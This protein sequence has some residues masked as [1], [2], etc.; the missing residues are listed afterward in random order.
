MRKDFLAALAAG[1]LASHMALAA[2]FRI[3]VQEDPDV[4]DPHRA[5]TT[6]GRMVF[7]S[8]CDKLVD[9]TDKLEIAPQLASSWS[10]STDNKTLTFKL[11]DDV[12]FHDG[13]TFDASAVKANLDRAMTLPDSMRKGELGSV[14]RVEVVDPTTVVLQLKQADA[15]LLSQLTDRAGMMLSPASF[16]GGDVGRKPICSGPYRFVERVQNDR[17]VLE[18]FP[19]YRDAKDYHFDRVI[20]LPIPDTTV[21][22]ANLQAGDLELVERLNPSDAEAVKAD[23]NLAFIVLPGL[24]FQNL[25][26]N[27]GPS[28]QADTPLGRDKLVRQALQAAI[29]RD[30]VNE[31]IGHGLFDPAQHPFPP[32]S[33]YF[34]KRYPVTTRDVAK[35]KALLA[36]ARQPEVAL[37]L[38]FGNTTITASLAEM[39]Q[40]MAGEAG[41]K[42]SLRPMEFAAMLSEMQK[43]NFQASLNGWSGRIDPDGNIHQ[44]VTC[45]G[46]QND[47]KYCNPEID[48]LLNEARLTPD[49][50]TR[51]GLYGQALAILQSD[52]PIIYTYYQPLL[53]A[54]SK[55][56]ADFKPYPDGM[57][58]LRGV[59]PAR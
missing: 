50:E 31:V 58:R 12:T 53:Y 10:W 48:R 8:L 40:A 14:D 20:F 52:L 47:S 23:R 45:K 6:V 25:V 39:V 3:G 13:T 21:R 55:R 5:R 2:D 7:T 43:G 51:K 17:I 42:I 34:D 19:G 36:Q 26:I 28:S 24:G 46:A 22:L 33:P 41:F 4:L 9:V 27:V 38:S 35:A 37:E 56:V 32:A 54:V 29:G 11:R 1:I 18:K 44:F 57:I 59:R 30:V 15:T 49:V 16:N